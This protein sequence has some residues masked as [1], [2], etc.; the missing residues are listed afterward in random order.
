MI[1]YITTENDQEKKTHNPKK[2]TTWIPPAISLDFRCAAFARFYFLSNDELLEI[3]S[4]TK[5]GPGVMVMAAWPGGV[6]WLVSQPKKHHMKVVVV[7]DPLDLFLKIYLLNVGKLKF[8]VVVS[9][10]KWIM[11]YEQAF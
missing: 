9:N 10:P 4:Q 6:G 7:E 5:V 11:T 3:L 1:I 2:Q 8:C